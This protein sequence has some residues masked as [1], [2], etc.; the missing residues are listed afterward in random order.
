MLCD[1]LVDR[2]KT[3]FGLSVHLK[4]VVYTLCILICMIIG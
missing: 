3:M 2:M 1:K 4:N